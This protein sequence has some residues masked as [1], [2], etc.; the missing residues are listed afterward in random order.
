MTSLNMKLNKNAKTDWEI[1]KLIKF[2]IL[3]SEV[4]FMMFTVL[5]IVLRVVDVGLHSVVMHQLLWITVLLSRGWTIATA[6]SLAAA[7]NTLTNFNAYPLCVARVIFGGD[8]RKHVTPLLRDKLHWLRKRDRITFKLCLLFYKARNGMA[9]NYIQDLSVPVSTVFT[10]SAL[11]SITDVPDV[12]TQRSKAVTNTSRPTLIMQDSRYKVV[13]FCV[14]CIHCRSANLCQP[15]YE[16]SPSDWGTGWDKFPSH[17]SPAQFTFLAIFNRAAAILYSCQYRTCAIFAFYPK[18]SP[19]FYKS[20]FF[21]HHRIMHNFIN[22]QINQ[23]I[24]H[25]NF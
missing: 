5:C 19:H 7:S 4:D 1:E 3:I 9:P 2:P 11:R 18:Q 10:R 22:H 25:D 20:C 12:L 16:R 8:R 15:L 23:S 17:S 21:Y 24:K 13:A 14:T 6:F